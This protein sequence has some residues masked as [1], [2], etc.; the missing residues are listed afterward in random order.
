MDEENWRPAE[1]K[2][3]EEW[4]H[5]ESLKKSTPQERRL[6][7][8]EHLDFFTY[9]LMLKV[10]TEYYFRYEGVCIAASHV[11]KEMS[12]PFVRNP[13][14]QNFN[15]SSRILDAD[16]SSMLRPIHIPVT[17]QH[18]SLACHERSCPDSLTT[19]GRNE[20]VDRQSRRR[21]LGGR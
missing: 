10:R 11:L 15:S 7:N 6:V 1:D 14:N 4:I 20:A 8:Y 18:N 16:Y 5:Q 9:W 3:W 19:V 21:A 2:D 13:D 12:F 17:R